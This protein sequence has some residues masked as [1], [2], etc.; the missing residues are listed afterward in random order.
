MKDLVKKLNDFKEIEPDEKYWHVSRSILLN[1]I[2]AD[3][4]EQQGFQFKSLFFNMNIFARSVFPTMKMA[5]VS[6]VV[7]V[8]I[9]L[10]GLGAQAA[11]PDNFLFA[12]KLMMEKGQLLLA[13]NSDKTQIRFKHIGNRLKE[14]DELIEKDKI[15]HIAKATKNIESSLQE[16]KENLEI[17]KNNKNVDNRIV[18]ELATLI[19]LKTN[20]IS[21]TLKDKSTEAEYDGIKDT[22]RASNSLSREALDVIVASDTELVD[23]ELELIENSINNKI[24]IQRDRFEE[25]GEKVTKA[26]EG[27]LLIEVEGE[28]LEKDLNSADVNSTTLEGET[29]ET[30]VEFNISEIGNISSEEIS[31]KLKEAK[32]L[33]EE[34][35]YTN[36]LRKLKEAEFYID[37]TDEATDEALEEVYEEDIEELEQ[38]IQEEVK[39]ET[40]QVLE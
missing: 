4:T 24:N 40:E 11:G 37:L 29:Q 19:D 10:T 17:M 15:T 23:S 31:E 38:E 14:I 39:G 32:E 18:V 30:P 27:V 35:D 26:Q 16:V 2:E 7:I 8:T 21:E 36:A 22:I 25:I 33:L 3:T 34:N 20:E 1:T 28:N 6:L 12:G 13:R 5:T 9:F